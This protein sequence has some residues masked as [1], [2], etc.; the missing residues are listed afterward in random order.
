[1]QTV[2]MPT[3]LPTCCEFGGQDLDIL[4][5]TTAVLNRPRDHFKHQRN[6]GGLFAV[7][8]GVKGLILPPFAG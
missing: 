3:D 6:P 1:M 8:V 5:V 4:Y 2:V 7:H